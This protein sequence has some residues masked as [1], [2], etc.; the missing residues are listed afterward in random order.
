MIYT[1]NNNA[2]DAYAVPADLKGQKYGAYKLA[3]L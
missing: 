1:Y 3:S 2:N